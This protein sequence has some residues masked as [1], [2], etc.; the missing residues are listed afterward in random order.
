MAPTQLR[1][2][3]GEPLSG[4]AFVQDYVELHYDGRILRALANP[5]I[6]VNGNR[7]HFPDQGSRDALCLLI[8]NVVEDVFVEEGSS[9]SVCFA[10]GAVVVIP[11]DIASQ[12]GPEAAHYVP[13]IDQPIEV[14]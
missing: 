14:W 12:T 4:I 3:I 6:V 13:G 2:I 5:S 1:S 7:Y 11:L 10:D 9:I 8:G